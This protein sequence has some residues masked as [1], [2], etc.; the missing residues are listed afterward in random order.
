MRQTSNNVVPPATPCAA[1]APR[2]QLSTVVVLW[3]AEKMRESVPVVECLLSLEAFKILNGSVAVVAV[4][5]E[6]ASE[7]CDIPLPSP[8]VSHFDD[9]HVEHLWRNA[10]LAIIHADLHSSGRV[11]GVLDQRKIPT[12]WM[13]ARMDAKGLR[14]QSIEELA[15]LVNKLL[16]DER[17]RTAAAPE[18]LFPI[19]QL[20][21]LPSGCEKPVVLHIVSGLLS[22]MLSHFSHILKYVPEVTHKVLNFGSDDLSGVA[23]AAVPIQDRSCNGILRLLRAEKPDLLH[24]YSMASHAAWLP[25]HRHLAEWNLLSTVYGNTMPDG[26]GALDAVIYLNRDAYEKHRSNAVAWNEAAPHYELLN[27]PSEPKAITKVYAS[28]YQQI[29]KGS[30]ITSG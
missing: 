5:D 11:P 16:C 30:L 2:Y 12:L 17:L 14:A 26:F 25:A 15:P 7:D 4:G 20:R 8:R 28:L 29:F 21:W 19:S 13:G 22:P 23:A 9:Q 27:D 3:P 6:G 18:I 10:A 24:L 1:D